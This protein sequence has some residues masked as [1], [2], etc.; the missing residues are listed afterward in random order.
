MMSSITA[1]AVVRAKQLALSA[2]IACALSVEAL[3]GTARSFEECIHATRPHAGQVAV[4]KRMMQLL[5]PPSEVFASHNYEGKVQD[6][7]SLRCTPQVHGVCHDT[8]DFVEGVI[9]VELNSATDNPMI[10]SKEDNVTLALPDPNNQ[11]DSYSELGMTQKRPEDTYYE[12]EGGFVISGGNFHGEYPAKMADYLAIG[13]AELGNISERRL[14]RLVNPVISELPAFLAFDPGLD[15]GYMIPHCTSAAL[16]S[17]NKVLCHPA[18]NDT[19]S[20]SGSKEDHVS[21]GGMAARKAMSVVENVENV[22][23]IEI[24]AACQGLSLPSTLRSDI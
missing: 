8:I 19:I 24:L 10:F 15:S 21:M 11:R 22:I 13:V 7:Y 20:T 17:E 9:E 6:A 12:G 5:T 18:S 14:E 16:V 23:A 3:K 4:A 1:H 2:D